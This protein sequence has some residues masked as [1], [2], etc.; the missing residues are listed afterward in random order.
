[1]L[2]VSLIFLSLNFI[3]NPI[4]YR[5]GP[6]GQWF[7]VFVYFSCGFVVFADFAV[8]GFAVSIVAYNLRFPTEIWCGFSVFGN[9][10]LWFCGFYRV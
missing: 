6:G 1:M 3:G 10:E 5:R 2:L 8:C 9:F 7:E 4:L